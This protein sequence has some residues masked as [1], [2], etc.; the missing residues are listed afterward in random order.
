MQLLKI[1]LSVDGVMFTTVK[2][3]KHVT[4]ADCYTHKEGN[5]SK[6]MLI[7]TATGEIMNGF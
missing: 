1:M 2:R 7:I 3:K 6:D 4:K 5:F